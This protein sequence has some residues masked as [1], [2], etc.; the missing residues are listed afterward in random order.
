MNEQ[1]HLKRVLSD[2]RAKAMVAKNKSIEQR[3]KAESF[4]EAAEVIEDELRRF[5]KTSQ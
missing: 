1:E 4:N 5:P 3:I 2:I